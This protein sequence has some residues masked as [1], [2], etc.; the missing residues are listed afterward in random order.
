MSQPRVN[1]W[2]SVYRFKHAYVFLLPLIVL[3]GLFSYYPIVMALKMSFYHWKGGNE[4]V[5]IGFD[6]FVTLFKDKA[7]YVS[8]KN[9]LWFILFDCTVGVLMPLIVAELLF[10]LKSTRLQYV[11]RT[12]FV[13]TITVPSVI[14]ILIWVFLYNPSIGG[15]NVLVD[16]IGISPQLWLGG[17]DTALFSIIFSGFP[18]INPIFLLIVFAALQAIPKSLHEASVMEGCGVWK[19]ILSID[20][21]LILGQLKLI[22]IL[23][24]L[25]G[26][27]SFYKQMI[28]TDGGPGNETLVPGLH[29]FQAGFRHNDFGYASTIG[30]VMLILMLVLTIVSN[31]LIKTEDDH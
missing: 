16:I 31:K 8:L 10:H 15:M 24:I 11:Y 29:M 6:N 26:M 3:L 21:P 30:F 9:A 27:Q 13:A 14:I 19:R 22:F 28:M 23:G 5:F 25:H 4:A 20:I 7:F 2:K 18:F 17:T 12:L 1:L